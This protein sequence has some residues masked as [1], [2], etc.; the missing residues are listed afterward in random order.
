M[1]NKQQS[2]ISN[3]DFKC[4]DTIKSYI[5]LHKKVKIS[6]SFLFDL[7]NNRKVHFIINESGILINYSQL[8]T[9]FEYLYNLYNKERSERLKKA[10]NEMWNESYDNTENDVIPTEEEY[11]MHYINF[12]A[13]QKV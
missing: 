5:L 12:I 8:E 10:H 6:S 2:N 1:N 4:F 13:K 11:E 7:I 3:P 9:N